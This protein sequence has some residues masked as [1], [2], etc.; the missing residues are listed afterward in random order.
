MGARD[1]NFQL[2][3]VLMA[4]RWA[5][6]RRRG[7]VWGVGRSRGRGWGVA[8]A[9]AICVPSVWAGWGKTNTLLDFLS[10]LNEKNRFLRE[11]QIIV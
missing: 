6:I 8:G 9:A 3:G 1:R 7:C 11:D 4:M 2:S 10:F 5:I